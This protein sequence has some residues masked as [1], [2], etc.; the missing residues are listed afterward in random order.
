[1]NSVPLS[2]YIAKELT[3]LFKRSLPNM[4]IKHPLLIA[5][6][7]AVSY[8]TGF[9][10]LIGGGNALMAQEQTAVDS[11]QVLP[12]EEVE[13]AL[14]KGDFETAR[15]LLEK[16]A[17]AKDADTIGQAQFRLG[18]MLLEGRG[19]PTDT[20]RGLHLLNAA[21]R[22]DHPPAMLIL[23]QLYLR[24]NLVKK[25]PK[26]AANLLDRAAH[27]GSVAAQLNLGRLYQV[28][29]GVTGN[30]ETAVKLFEKATEN[31]SEE[32]R[33]ELSKH[34]SRGWGVEKD[35]DKALRFL[36]KS[37]EAGLPE[38]QLFLAFNYMQGSGVSKDTAQGLTWMT[39]AAESGQPMAQRVLGT[40]YLQGEGVEQNSAEAIRWLT[41]AAEAGEAGAQSNLGY[42]Y[43]TG[44]GAEQD[45]AKAFS[46]YEKASEQGLLRATTALASLYERGQGVSENLQQAIDL[47]REAAEQGE[48]RAQGR[49]AQL[50]VAGKTELPIKKSQGIIWIASLVLA[51]DPDA[52]DWLE[53]QAQAGNMTAQARLGHYYTQQNSDNESPESHAK[54]LALLT[55]AAERGDAFGQYHLAQLYGT[56]SG[57]ELD[58]VQAHKWVNLSAARGYSDAAKSRDIYAKLM[59]PEQIAE[60]QKLARAYVA[61]N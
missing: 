45:L 48:T 44:T 2:V 60:A 49:L 22:A 13:A 38:A 21:A 10:L 17:E 7:L 39:R 55:E 3:Q 40:A 4:P 28:G 16:L 14:T 58:Y 51:G 11:N 18:H 52:R 37:A 15:S 27:L 8:T 24:G 57:V 26:S 61:K 56:G 6:F 1:L 33:F 36:T 5:S 31:G 32:A 9:P 43:A 41:L 46:W 50:I 34:Y 59:T 53:K 30:P 35:T 42:I 29:H 47:Y 19:G 20:E 23:A 12:M 54:A 25:D